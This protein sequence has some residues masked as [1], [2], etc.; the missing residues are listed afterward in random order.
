[1]SKDDYENDE[2]IND[3]GEFVHKED[4]IFN[5]RYNTGE[6]LKDTDEYE[7][8]KKIS[9]S[10]DYSD[11]YL[12]DVYE[13]EE[14]LETQ[15]ILDGIFDFI[16]KDDSLNKMVFHSYNDS[17]VFK[18]KFAKDEI[19]IIFNKIHTSLDESNGQ[20]TFY[21]PIYVLEAISSFS[22]FD[23]KKIFDS[24]D[25]ESQELLL[26]E[27]DKKYKFLDGKMHKKKIH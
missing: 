4:K 26:V 6:G 10:S 15:F 12:K 22:G 1:M 14:N 25:T 3:S 9:V 23:Y 16:K 13:Y 2:N 8:S 17:I 21:S 5:N 19:N 24:L 18:N 27:L 7:F 11:S 20:T